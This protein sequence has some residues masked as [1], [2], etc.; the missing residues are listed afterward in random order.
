VTTGIFSPPD[1]EMTRRDDGSIVLASR[2]PLADHPRSVGVWLER[3]ANE[4]PDGVFLAERPDGDHTRPWNTITYRAMWDSARA[5]GQ[6]LLDGDLGPDRPLAILSGPSIAHGQLKL[7]GYLVGV[8]VVSVSVAY[9]LQAQDLGK[10]NHILSQ[11]DPGLVFVERSAPFSRVLDAN[12]DRPVISG[13]GERGRPLAEL[14]ATAPTAEVDEAFAAVDG[15]HVAKILYTSGSTGLPKGVLTIH[16]M[17]CSNQMAVLHAWPFL[18]ETPPVIC[19]WLPWSHT[20]AGSHDL[21]M[22]LA[23]GGTLYIDGGK[24]A[25]G[26]FDATVANLASARPTISLNVPAGYARLVDRLEADDAF[27]AAFFERLQLIFYAAAALPQDVWERLETLAERTVGRPIP[28]TSSW[29]LT[30]TAPAATSAH[31]PLDRAGVIG[32]PLPGVELKLAPN[33]DKM[34]IRVKGPGV[35]PG[36]HRDPE[37]TAAAFDDEGWFITGDAVKLADPADPNAGL[38]FDGRVAEDFKLMTGTW[39]SVGTLR[40][41]ILATAAPLITDCVVTGHDRNELGLL[42]W[43]GA[44]VDDDYRAALVERLRA[45]NEA[46]NNTSSTRVRRVAILDE[47]PSIDRGETT[48]KGYINQRA[49]LEARAEVV[50][51]L[52]AADPSDAGVDPGILFICP[53]II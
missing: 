22:V 30:E 49:T 51:R 52:Y 17:L 29:G 8:P 19:D 21:N 2:A 50:D 37:K 39:V 4:R 15:D 47:P 41:A 11:C 26:L 5:L 46:F 23:H 18:A 34:E 42:V 10:V 32:V 7:A 28:M 13:D 25:P 48:D 16:R 31:F 36:Y 1:I 44:P 12:P 6:A 45:H 27:A 35:T 38:V 33:G 43:P 14:L 53:Q 20:F 9:S 40:P 3:W 24:P